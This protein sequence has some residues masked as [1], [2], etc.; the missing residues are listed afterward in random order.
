MS[1]INARKMDGWVDSLPAAF[2]RRS[3]LLSF[4]EEAEVSIKTDACLTSSSV[5][6]K[7]GLFF[8]SY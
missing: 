5:I 4:F 1:G 6:R 8:T 7:T 2:F 3:S